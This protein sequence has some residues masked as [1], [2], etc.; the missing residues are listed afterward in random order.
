MHFTN[1]LI[2]C[3]AYDMSDGVALSCGACFS[4]N[5]HHWMRCFIRCFIISTN[6]KTTDVYCSRIY[7]RVTCSS[8]GRWELEIYE[9]LF[10]LHKLTEFWW[11]WKVTGLTLTTVVF[12]LLSI[13]VSSTAA[14][15]TGFMRVI[16]IFDVINVW[17][18]GQTME[19]ECLFYCEL[20]CNVNLRTATLLLIINIFTIMWF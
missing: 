19:I 5:N 9:H 10:N 17:C 1:M 7:G 2:Q 15:H 12:H 4:D 6:Y 14:Q 13:F 11:G 8:S 16:L 3:Q 20:M 18:G